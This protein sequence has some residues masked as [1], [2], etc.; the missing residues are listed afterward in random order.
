MLLAIVFVAPTTI[1]IATSFT[2]GNMILFP[3][4]GFSFRW[5]EELFTT[6]RWT[7]AFA[8]S[9]Q[10][11]ILAALLA[12]ILGTLLGLGAARGRGLVPGWLIMGLALS[13]MVVPT[14]VAA[15]GFYIAGA[16][17]GGVG[18][19]IYLAIAHAL[20]GLPFVFINV[21]ASL[22][23]VSE[24]VEEAARISGASPLST[25]LRITLP[26]ILPSALVGG[27]LAFVTSFDEYIIASFLTSPWL[28]TLPVEMFADVTTGAQPSTSAVSTL[29]TAATLTILC[30]GAAIP[31]LMRRRRKAN[32]A[33]AAP[34]RN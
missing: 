29:V 2:S 11:G 30:L 19:W 1:V 22:G 15:V 33:H 9:F 14:V 26:L 18:N 27:L 24:S 25:V 21:L 31:A 32:L 13:P 4:Q 17:M 12:M 23:S 34:G 16:N 5:Y 8:T 3:P 7:N 10:V 6:P 28:R 20:M